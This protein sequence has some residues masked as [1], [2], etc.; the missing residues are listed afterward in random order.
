MKSMFRRFRYSV[1]ASNGPKANLAS[2]KRQPSNPADDGGP[3][4]A[5]VGSGPSGLKG[6]AC[7]VVGYEWANVS[8]ALTAQRRGSVRSAKK[9]RLLPLALRVTF[10]ENS[11]TPWSSRRPA[12]R[13]ERRVVLE[14]A[15]DE[16]ERR[17]STLIRDAL[18][19]SP[20]FAGH[21]R[22]DG[23]LDALVGGG[24]RGV[25][26]AGATRGDAVPRGRDRSGAARPAGPWRGSRPHAASGDRLRGEV[27][28]RH[29]RGNRA[30]TGRPSFSPPRR[31]SPRPDW[32]RDRRGREGREEPGM[33]V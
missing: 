6:T 26:L 28:R 30:A 17:V 20:G 27:R 18:E 29:R 14:L 33:S 3:A 15:E 5:G 9:S 19:D 1:S 23:V 8:F 12:P 11:L 25:R 2:S 7:C 32:R 21:E 16:A 31:A 10:T 22:A 13:T 24:D 4:G